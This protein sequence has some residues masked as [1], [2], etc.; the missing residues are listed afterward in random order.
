MVFTASHRILY[1]LLFLVREA[2]LRAAAYKYSRRSKNKTLSHPCGYVYYL[3]FQCGVFWHSQPATFIPFI[4]MW[5][6]SWTKQF[7]WLL[8]KVTNFTSNFRNFAVLNQHRFSIAVLPIDCKSQIWNE[9]DIATAKTS[10][11]E[12]R[13]QL[14]GIDRWKSFG[15]IV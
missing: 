11:V 1:T 7:S 12:L 2:E 9:I 10:S 4:W 14:T 13:S 3:G 15:V 6:K 8:D 5:E